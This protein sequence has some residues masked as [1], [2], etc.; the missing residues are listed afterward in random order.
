MT[1]G[2]ALGL[3]RKMLKYERTFRIVVALEANLILRPTGSQLPWQERAVRVVTVIAGDQSLVNSMPIGPAEFGTLLGVALI[4]EKWCLLDQQRAFGLSV[5]R[6][7][8]VETAN[9][10]GRMR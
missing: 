9:T 4:A 8:T 7:M 5:V 2:A 1:N 10:V 6:R 3:H